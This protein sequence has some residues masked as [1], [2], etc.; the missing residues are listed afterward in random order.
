MDSLLN[1]FDAR[2]FI[3]ISL[4]ASMIALTF[5]LALRA[6]ESDAFKV[7]LGAMLTVGFTSVI[8]WYF[9]SSAGS[10]KKDATIAAAMSSPG[11]G[12][13]EGSNPAIAAAAA[14]AAA[15]AAAEAAV[16]QALAHPLPQL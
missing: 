8:G 10:D 14:A 12:N 1:R 15:P 7:L 13:G 6:P 2:A 9:A 5:V 11:G 4:T 3:A 16:A